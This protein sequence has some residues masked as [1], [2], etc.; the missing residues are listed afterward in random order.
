VSK[1][2]LTARTLLPS[3]TDNVSS[4]QIHKE[5]SLNAAEIAALVLFPYC[6]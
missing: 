3:K 4:L 2:L 6:S 5:E 1:Y